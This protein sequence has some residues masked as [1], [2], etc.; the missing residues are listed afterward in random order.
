MRRAI[1]RT[2]LALHPSA[3]RR[4]FAD[5]MLWVFDQADRDREAS[6]FCADVAG[7]LLRHWLRQPM[8][9]RIA[10]AAAGGVLMLLWMSATAP[11]IRAKWSALEMDDL[12]ILAIGSL[13]AISLTLITTVALFHS[14]RR[15][16]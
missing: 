13:L 4:Q 14:T 12:L 1:Y 6:G 2:L 11:R 5:E 8:L 15:R 16:L 3:F 10:G 9:W 7:S